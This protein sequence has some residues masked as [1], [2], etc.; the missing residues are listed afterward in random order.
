MSKERLLVTGIVVSLAFGA[1]SAV[2]AQQAGGGVSENE[3]QRAQW[4]EEYSNTGRWGSEDELGTLNLITAR[5]RREAAALVG[6]GEV[7]SLSR[8][9]A[10]VDEPAEL[11]EPTS[12]FE[13]E[14]STYG[15]GERAEGF[16]FD[17][18]AIGYHGSS[19]THL[20]GLCHVSYDG[21][22]YNDFLQF[23][24]VDPD[25][26]C[27]RLGI[28]GLRDGIVTRGLLVDLAR[29]RGVDAVGPGD[30]LTTADV[31][32]WERMTGLHVSPGDALFLYTGWVPGAVGQ[33]ANY[34]PSIVAFLRERDVALV[35]A[36]RVSGDH[37]LTIA[38]LGAYLIDNADLS[39]AV[40]TSARLDRW[41]FMLMIAPIP[42]P[43]GT[44]SIVN[45][46][47]MY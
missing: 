12:Y 5:K 34:D 47:A 36:D 30:S 7:V 11:T 23:D 15:P 28:E 8:P 40:E 1:A 13:V 2:T 43:E 10:L 20:D 3:R 21:R 46:L 45:P 37:Q 44:G 25:M 6:A 19:Y 27:T 4:A 9:I 42:T 16:S 26:G 31:L 32:T 29:V 18:Q 14:F 41:E 33:R 39:R 38:T 22:L 17:Y 24:T 35:G